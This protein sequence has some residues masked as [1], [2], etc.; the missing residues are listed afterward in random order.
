MKKYIQKY[1]FVLAFLYLFYILLIGL[2]IGGSY[3]YLIMPLVAPL[4]IIIG[5]FVWQWQEDVKNQTAK[6]ELYKEKYNEKAQDI[7][8]VY[9]KYEKSIQ[10]IYRL[11]NDL[12][13]TFKQ[14]PSRKIEKSK[15]ISIIMSKISNEVNLINEIQIDLYNDVVL[16]YHLILNKNNSENHQINVYAEAHK[17]I[18]TL[19]NYKFISELVSEFV[20]FYL[21]DE[22]IQPEKD[23]A[24][25]VE[26]HKLEPSIES[27][28]FGF[29]DNPDDI[30][31][32]APRKRFLEL[33]RSI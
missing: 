17:L 2:I 28:D 24:L 7:F 27:F 15:K 29:S 26:F 14:N 5:I 16:F 20:E 12:K 25:M 21:H 6:N 23:I 3:Q 4:T 8:G 33:T 19:C 32:T 18:N 31:F 30:I 13:N 1:P 10:N 11:L 9:T 22:R